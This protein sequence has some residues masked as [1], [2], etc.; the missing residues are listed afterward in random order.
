MMSVRTGAIRPMLVDDAEFPGLSS[1]LLPTV[2]VDI[3]RMS[4]LIDPF[5]LM[6]IFLSCPISSFPIVKSGVDAVSGN[7]HLKIRKHSSRSRRVLE[8]AKKYFRE[9]EE[10][11]PEARLEKCLEISCGRSKGL[12]N[13]DGW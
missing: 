10:K 4:P 5:L 12:S 7:I 3:L 13:A 6:Q 8:H 9:E 11:L 2:C 1:F